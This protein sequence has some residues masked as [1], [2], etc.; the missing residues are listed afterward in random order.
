MICQNPKALE[1]F[2]RP[3]APRILHRDGQE[4]SILHRLHAATM[5]WGGVGLTQVGRFPPLDDPLSQQQHWHQPPSPSTNP[6]IHPSI[7]AVSP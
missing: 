2:K 4:L 6:S 5:G 7:L 1:S 3:P